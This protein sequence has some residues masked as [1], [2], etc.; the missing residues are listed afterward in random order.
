VEEFKKQFVLLGILIFTLLLFVMVYK[1]DYFW[2]IARHFPLHTNSGNCIYINDRICLAEDSGL[3]VNY[4]EASSLCSKRGM[5]LPTLDD[6][7]EIWIASENC[8]R[9]F[10]SNHEVPRGKEA[11]K[12]SCGDI[13]CTVP[14]KN[15][16]NYYLP[17]QIKFP[18]SSQYKNGSFWLRNKAYGRQHYGINYYSGSVGDYH[19]DV[20]TLGVRCVSYKHL[21]K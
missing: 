19:D 21:K 4:Y 13:S 8:Q 20:K 2:N 6:A 9:D 11:F 14:A 7:W 5:Y 12:K 10:D 16:K 17:S 3:R 1:L 18:L 15:I